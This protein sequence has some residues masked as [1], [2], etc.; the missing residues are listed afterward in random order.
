MKVMK[1]KTVMLVV[2]AMAL[3]LVLG[4][5]GRDLSSSGS[6]RIQPTQQ[7]SSGGTGSGGV[8]AP[9]GSG[10]PVIPN[11][12][13]TGQTLNPTGNLENDIKAVVKAARPAVVLIAV[14]I[15]TG[16]GGGIFG[17][18]GQVG[19]GVGSG[20]IISQ[21]GYI[22]TNN[23]VVEGATG[24]IR[25]SLPDGRNYTARLIG[26]EGTN[27]DIAVIKIDPKAGETL[28]TI[29]LGDS[30]K[31]EVGDY[32]VAIGNALGL[33]GGPTVT[34]GL[35][36]NIGRSI[37]E[38]NGATLTDLIQTDAA[39]NP[40]NSGGPLLNLS[41]EQIGV[42]TAAAVNPEENTAAQNIGFAINVNQAR[43]YVNA[44]GTGGGNNGSQAPAAGSRPFMGVYPQ[45]M[46][47]ALATRYNLP[48][49][50]GVLI[51]RV[52][53]N[54]PA[55]KAGWKAGD[56]MIGM[57]NQ[58]INNTNDLQ[59]VLNRHKAGDTVTV[60]L[61]DQNGNRRNAPITFGQAPAQP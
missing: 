23:H 24:A 21:D 9:V 61:V 38:P 44:F 50:N 2:L 39:I 28:P 25:V 3:G 60:T 57:D 36:S 32:V 54:S 33:P 12:N 20:S 1:Y 4:A 11:L 31:M 41:G 30:S 10:Q 51:A 46:T 49:S 27:S 48:I 52:D 34:G 37:Q 15:Q 22:L 26:R 13:Q 43:Q 45:T 35:I 14:T 40:G 56:I 5:C 16:G 7:V 29:K 8:G 18:G 58:Q 6:S 59:N 17:G 53:A 42:N 55:A 47:A 19:Q